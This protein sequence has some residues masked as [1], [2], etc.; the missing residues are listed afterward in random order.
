MGAVAAS[1]V[2]GLYFAFSKGGEKRIGVLGL[3]I[4]YVL[5]LSAFL[6]ILI[7]VWS[8]H[9]FYQ[10]YLLII[11]PGFFVLWA[12]LLEKLWKKWRGL[13]VFLLFL[14]LVVN[15]RTLVLAR[16]DFG[17]ER[18]IRAVEWT[19]ENLED[20]DFGLYT[21]ED[22]WLQ[23]GGWTYLFFYKKRGPMFS[24]GDYYL[25]QLFGKKVEERQT[26]KVVLMVEKGYWKKKKELFGKIE[27]QLMV[28]KSF[29]SF[30]VVIF[31]NSDGWVER[32][33]INF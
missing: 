15:L 8:G 30:E 9:N 25:S 4:L 11:L 1:L 16:V 6:G 31:D 3:K 14:Y 12:V 29:E 22:G 27:R 26:K 19:I 32:E 5:F 33:K 18:K 2:L 7:F 10:H 20:D 17:F 28:R 13:V 21:S 23:G 24:Y